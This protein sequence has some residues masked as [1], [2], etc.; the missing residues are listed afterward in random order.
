MCIWCLTWRKILSI[1]YRNSQKSFSIFPQIDIRHKHITS[2]EMDSFL[3]QFSFDIYHLFF[4]STFAILCSRFIKSHFS[5]M[6]SVQKKNIYFA[7]KKLLKNTLKVFCLYPIYVINFSMSYPVNSFWHAHL[8]KRG[9]FWF[10]KCEL[11]S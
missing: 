1:S 9:Q 10:V 5:R 2:L 3:F 11:S 7:F 4:T 6:S 8:Q